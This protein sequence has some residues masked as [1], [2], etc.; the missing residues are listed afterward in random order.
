VSGRQIDTSQG[1]RCFLAFTPMMKGRFVS[2]IAKK[3]R[4]YVC[5]EWNDL[6]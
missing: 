5:P 1:Q 6:I 4:E 2:W 3:G